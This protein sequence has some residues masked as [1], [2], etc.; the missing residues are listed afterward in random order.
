MA[1]TLIIGNS[2]GIGLALT[3]RLLAD[4]GED[5]VGISRSPSPIEDPRYTHHVM[6]VCDPD[7]RTLLGGLVEERGA[8]AACVYCV[9]IGE[10]FDAKAP[11]LSYDV[12][13]FEV[14][15]LGVVKTAEVLLP[16]MLE[17][18][19]GHLVGLSSLADAPTPVSA[20]AYGASKAGMSAYL[21]GLALALRGTGVRVSNVRFGFVDTKM[22][23]ADY[24]PFQLTASEA[25]THVCAVLERRPIRRSRPLLM[26]A[27][28]MLVAWVLN[29]VVLLT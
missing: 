19:A 17:E 8:P 14:N 2:D 29:G 1:W 23:K 24:K 9:G 4:A 7:Y 16:A 26:A 3:R 10:P 6:D 27:L 13:T 18:G 25:A 21:E 15:L 20:P 22:A 28:M 12:R 5:R 11:D